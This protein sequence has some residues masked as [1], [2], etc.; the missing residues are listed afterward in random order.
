MQTKGR[1][2]PLP[3]L[4]W[5]LG[6]VCIVISFCFKFYTAFPFS[7]LEKIPQVSRYDSLRLSRLHVCA[8]KAVWMPRVRQKG[9]SAQSDLFWRI[10][11]M[12]LYAICCC[13]IAIG[14]FNLTQSNLA[15]IKV[16]W[17]RCV[18]R[19]FDRQDPGLDQT[20]LEFIGY[21][22]KAACI[23]HKNSEPSFHLA[24]LRGLPA[25]SNISLEHSI[26]WL[27]NCL[28]RI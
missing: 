13:C 25:L 18:H 8:L 2:G 12:Q 19:T 1:F 5:S 24:W 21:G 10:R 27:H 14:E 22:G 9:H 7:L 23:K 3:S 28:I 6:N 26:N 4:P 20:P 16:E 17:I 11:Q 15:Q